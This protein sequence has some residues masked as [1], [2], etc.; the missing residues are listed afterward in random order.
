MKLTVFNGSG[1]GK[2]G[3]T[4]V[5]VD[6]FVKGFTALPDNTVE[7][8]TLMQTGRMADFTAAFEQAQCVL[9]A[10]PMYTDMV[11][12]VVKAFIETLQPFCGRESNPELLFLIQCGFPEAVQLR[13]LEAYLEKLSRRLGCKHAGAILRGHVE[14][15]RDA[16]PEQRAPLLAQYET[17]GRTYA[18]TGRLDEKIL[19]G[20]SQPERI[21]KPAVFLMRLLAFTN[22]M[23]SGWNRE[24]KENNAYG[25]RFARPDLEQN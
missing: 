1:R 12:G 21:P 5:L 16:T 7:I 14:G 13:A 23:D 25:Q 2:S 9:M 11:P 19:T 22:L 6:A 18:E 4:A 10:F 24:L 17:L 8:H 20:L 15:I 3:N